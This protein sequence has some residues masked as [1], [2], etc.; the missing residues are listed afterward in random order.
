MPGTRYPN[1][2]GHPPLPPPFKGGKSEA[3]GGCYP[4]KGGKRLASLFSSFF[5]Q[6]L[7]CRMR[8][9]ILRLLR[10]LSYFTSDFFCHHAF[11]THDER[12]GSV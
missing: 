8:S 1:A 12:A 10:D 3:K 2:E 11:P 9:M 7:G 6:W 4:F 5:R